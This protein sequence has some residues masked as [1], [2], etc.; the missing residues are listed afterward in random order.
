MDHSNTRRRISPRFSGAKI[1]W[2]ARPTSDQSFQGSL[3]SRLPLGRVAIV[4]VQLVLKALT[5][6][7]L[8]GAKPAYVDG[9]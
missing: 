9:L 4:M 8:R 1:H 7:W 5:F 2:K 3:N 6:F